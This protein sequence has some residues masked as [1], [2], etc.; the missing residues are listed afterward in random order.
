[1]AYFTGSS[2]WPAAKK[3]GQNDS[4]DNVHKKKHQMGIRLFSF[5]V[6]AYNIQLV[7]LKYVLL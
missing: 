4:G 1:M 3:P 6:F 2:N 7:Y 5:Y